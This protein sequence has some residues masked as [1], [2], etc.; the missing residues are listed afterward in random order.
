M[1]SFMALAAARAG[2]IALVE[3]PELEGRGIQR[4]SSCGDP[5]EAG[6]L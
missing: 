4:G 3:E 2:E 5:V 1:L 6:G